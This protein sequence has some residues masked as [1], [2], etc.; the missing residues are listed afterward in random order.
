MNNIEKWRLI[1][2]GISD[3]KRVELPW[4]SASLDLL[5]KELLARRIKGNHAKMNKNYVWRDKFGKKTPIFEIETK[6]LYNI[7]CYLERYLMEN[8]R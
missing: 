5:Y 8:K 6:Y 4:T 2:L 7:I 1:G 3:L